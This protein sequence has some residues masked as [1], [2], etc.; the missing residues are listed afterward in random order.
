MMTRMGSPTAPTVVF[1]HG[2]VINRQMWIP[3]MEYLG[4]DFDCV[5][6]DLPGHGAHSATPF[7]MEA[8]RRRVA[9]TFDEIG[10]EGAAL[11]GLS[12]GGY[13]ALDFTRVWPE[14]VNGLVLSGATISYTGWDGV[15][16]RLYGLIFPLV[17]RKAEKAFAEKLARD[18]GNDRAREILDVGLSMRGG[19]AALRVLPGT[20]YAAEIDSSHVPIVIA[21][22]ERDTQNRSGEA[23]FLQN[24]PRARVTVIEDAG[25]ACAIQ[26][27]AAFAGAVRSLMDE[28]TIA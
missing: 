6:I 27:P 19:G 2:G 28:L 12:L 25:H 17:A 22:G 21:N 26:Q 24:H 15:S 7:S 23:H 13:V 8:S 11:V 9:D 4:D 10:V 5:A 3:V 16:T 1:L 14:R 18:L 20:D